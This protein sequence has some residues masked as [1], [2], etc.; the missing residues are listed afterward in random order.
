MLAVF[1]VSAQSCRFLLR[2]GECPFFPLPPSS[3]HGVCVCVCN[4]SFKADAPEMGTLKSPAANPWRSASADWA[5]PSYP[6][7]S[8][9]G[10]ALPGRQLF[11]WLLTRWGRLIRGRGSGGGGRSD[12][13]PEWPNSCVTGAVSGSLA[14]LDHQVSVSWLFQPPR[15]R[16]LRAN[17][18]SGCFG[19][20]AS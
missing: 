12:L 5:I 18:C 19:W 16:P 7:P 8:V 10:C 6:S 1:P 20:I 2:D 17:R 11:A 3:T 4:D 15:S 9:V 14:R 13:P